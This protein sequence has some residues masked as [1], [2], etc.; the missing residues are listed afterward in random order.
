MKKDFHQ[1]FNPRF[2]KQFERNSVP[3]LKWKSKTS[4]PKEG[5]NE[6]VDNDLGIWSKLFYD[7]NGIAINFSLFTKENCEYGENVKYLGRPYCH[8]E[9]KKFLD[10]I[11]ALIEVTKDSFDNA[12]LEANKVYSESIECKGPIRR[13]I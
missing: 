9:T 8:F 13:P 6:L 1:Q 2:E 12:Q 4:Y 3:K 5:L 7:E 10:V 11:V